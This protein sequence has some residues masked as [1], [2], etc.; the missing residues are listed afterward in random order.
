MSVLSFGKCVDRVS[1]QPTS[2]LWSRRTCVPVSGPAR[3][4]IFSP[5]SEQGLFR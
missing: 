5:E 2:S 4:S 3:A 1:L